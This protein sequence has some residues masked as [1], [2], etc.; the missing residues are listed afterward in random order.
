MQGYSGST[1]PLYFSRQNRP[2]PFGGRRFLAAFILYGYRSHTVN[3][4]YFTP[5]GFTR[6]A[7]EQ[8]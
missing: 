4:V 5:H 6:A 3:A 1:R 2:V 7:M 8:Y